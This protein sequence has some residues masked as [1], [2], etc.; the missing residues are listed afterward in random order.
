MTTH[1]TRQE[2]AD[3]LQALV[4]DTVEDLLDR[5]LRG[6]RIPGTF[7]G[8][9]VEPDVPADLVFT[10]GWLHDLGVEEIGG[11]GLTESI[12]TVLGAIDGPKTH[13]FFSYRVAE[14]LARYGAFAGN[15]I[16]EDWTEA[17]R[18]NLARACD[19]TDWIPL[20]DQGL[21]RNYAAVLA[22]CEVVRQ[23]LGLGQDPGIV[24][25]LI[26]R[27]AAMLRA[28]PLGHL[29][30][31]THGIGRYD[32]YA[33]DV[34]LFTEPLAT[35]LGPMWVEGAG[36]ALDLVDAVAGDDG[37]AIPWGR[38][39]GV[40]GIALTI[41]LAALAAA[42]LP[43]A[44]PDRWLRR[45]VDAARQLPAWFEDGVIT[46]HRYRSPYGY[47]G[48]FRRLQ[49]TLD[50]LG[51][52]AWSA[53]QLRRA[54][55]L[56]AAAPADTYRPTDRLISFEEAR[57]VAVWA[58]RSAGAELVVPFVGPTRS[59]YLAAPRHPGVFE[60]PVDQPI[61][62]WVPLVIARGHRWTAAGVPESV[63]ATPGSVTATWQG[64]LEVGELDPPADAP[65]LSGRCST[66]LSI[67]G[68]TVR[69]GVELDL[70]QVPDAVTVLLPETR[71][72]PLHVELVGPPGTTAVL[73]TIDVGGIAE[74][75]SFWAEL[76]VLH[77]VDLDVDHHL[78]VTIEVTPKL[79]V[80][81][82]AY[83]HHY[84]RLL[85]GAMEDGVEVVPAPLGPLAPP[86]AS[87]DG[88]DVLHLHWP[89]WLAFDDV[90]VHR[91]LV[92][93][94]RKRSIPIVW[95]AH[96]L[97]PHEK[98]PEVYDAIYQL[99]ADAADG[100]IHH[101]AFGRRAMQ[102]RYRFRPDAVHVVIPHGHFGSLYDTAAAVPRDELEAALGLEPTTCRIG[103]FGAPRAEKDVLG[104]LDAVVASSRQDLQ[105]LCYSLRHGEQ[106]PDDPRLAAVENYAMVEAALYARRLAVCDLVAL[107][108]DPEGEMLAT[109]VAADV[110]GM[111]LGA[112]VSDWPYLTE[113]FGDAGIPMGST[114]EEMAAAIDDLDTAAVGRAK[115]ASVR[116]RAAHGWDVVGGRTMELYEAVL[117]RTR[118]DD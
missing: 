63:E 7:G 3:Q 46:A 20:L 108:F 52:L 1:A 15:P 116:L 48:P 49:M 51:K 78:E 114:V 36:R 2:L 17:Q 112:L 80:G 88:I 86:N 117:A 34:W 64:L 84:D 94:L 18:T 39:T 105:V 101:S 98:R 37:T 58:H 72:R 35:H 110:I 23:R 79:R 65:R 22:R 60:V 26:E 104:F 95:T 4:V 118:P 74:W 21:P 54:D 89:E 38:S 71:G 67:A 75:R 6:L 85:A 66:R 69:F 57:P 97:T 8:H 44:D 11:R 76:P 30:D 53:V 115:Q 91:R 43:A 42:E 111:G 27:T 40:L 16:T 92:A 59:D 96:N 29:D 100:V 28:N 50:V 77:Q 13:T 99:W 81:S 61:P 87:L 107:P 31:S 83:G 103:L 68:R 45:A 12:R 93:E 32:I 25:S 33:A 56:P 73:D 90:E 70:D 19:S 106:A 109:G 5:H 113:T 55:D 47:R 41:E 62:C 10:L 9:P 14:T 82:T 24:D 102:Q